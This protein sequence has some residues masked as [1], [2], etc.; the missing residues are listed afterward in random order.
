VTGTPHLQAVREGLPLDDSQAHLVESVDDAAEF[1]RWLST[2]KKVAFDTETTGLNHDTDRPR[3]AQ[4]G[5]GRDGWAIPFERWAG[6]VDDATRRYEGEYVMH[7][8][9][10]DW[11][12][13]KHGGVNLPRHRIHDTRLKAHV[14]SSTGPL[15]LKPL[16]ERH[17]D[18][19][20]GA[21]Q[22]AL[23]TGIGKHGG[24]TWANVPVTYEPYWVYAA[25]DTVLTYH[26]DEKLDPMVR[27]DAPLSYELEL[28]VQWVCEDMARRGAHVDR[29]YT[30]DLMDKMV[31]YVAEVA[32]WCVTHFDLKPGSNDAVA[33]RL[34]AEGVHLYKRTQA[35]RLSVDKDVLAGIDH[36]LAGAVLGHRQATKLVSTYLRHYLEM[37]TRDGRVHPSINT[38]GGSAKNPFEQGGTRGVRTGRMSMDEPNLQNVPIRTNQ[39]KKIRNCFDAMC[40]GWCGCGRPHSWIKADFDQIEMR[41]FA[42]LSNDPA[43]IELFRGD[44]DPFLVATRDIFADTTIL[45]E[46]LRRQHV[47]NSF[48]AKLYGAGVE[49]FAR[50]AGIRD[51]H[52]GLDLVLAQ[53]FLTRLDQMYPGIRSLQRETETTANTNR[54]RWG[55]AYVRSPLTN[56]KHVADEGREYA[57]MNYEVQG[58]AGEILKMK[59]VECDHAGL[60][61]YMV[62]PVHDEIDLDAPTDELDDVM[63]TLRDVMNDADLLTV[64]ITATMSVGDRWGEVKD[65]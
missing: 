40:G 3:M 32:A 50:T 29:A 60:G 17:V 55:E 53:A 12:M 11:I 27:G 51:E 26:L 19:R 57:L 14:I 65:V 48:Y 39:G 47:K 20:A 46:D 8:A 59:M 21:A 7:N 61:R 62:L 16:C 10:Y 2:K 34:V 49:Q 31:A 6:V 33:E 43:L 41:L 63:T 24:W 25:L 56:R 5:D 42:H 44:V 64:P 58:T 15:G 45:K 1:M 35:G 4:Y 13:M 23:E 9:P 28:A 18:P 52:G 54:Q 30:Q 38:V 37:S 36:P 22:Q